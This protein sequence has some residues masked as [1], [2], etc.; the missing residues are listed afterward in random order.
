M[1]VVA[2]ASR[3]ERILVVE[4]LAVQ[5]DRAKQRVVERLFVEVCE[6]SV[7]VCQVELMLEE[8]FA[9]TGAGFAVG[10]VA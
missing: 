8:D 3:I 9:A 5:I 6:F 1:P 7:V 10:A 2:P 4:V